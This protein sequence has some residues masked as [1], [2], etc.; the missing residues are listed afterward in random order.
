MATATLEKLQKDRLAMSVAGAL[1]IANEAALK[2]GTTPADC[3]V[4]I[5]EEESATGPVWRVSYGPRDYVHCRGGDLV[6]FIDGGS[7]T[8][9]RV[10]RGQ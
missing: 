8:V 1:A 7:Q 10:V 4:S 6:V 5:T 2:H 3:L 9:Q